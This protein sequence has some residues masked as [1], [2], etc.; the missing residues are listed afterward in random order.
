VSTNFTNYSATTEGRSAE[1]IANNGIISIATKFIFPSS[2]IVHSKFI[3][4]YFVDTEAKTQSFAIYA[5]EVEFITINLEIFTIMV[6]VD[7]FAININAITIVTTRN[8]FTDL[9][10]LYTFP[11]LLL[12]HYYLA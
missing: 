10:I 1:V 5:I 7:E 4:L 11:T 8:N 9:S 6:S 2:A 3:G 12:I